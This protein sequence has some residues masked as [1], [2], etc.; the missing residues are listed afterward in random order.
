MLLQFTHRPSPLGAMLLAWDEG[1]Q[2]R[3]LEFVDCEARLMG[4]LRRQYGSYELCSA[5][6]PMAIVDPLD[7]YFAGAIGNLDEITVATGG[8]EFQRQVWAALRTIGPGE[9][10]SY[11][12]LAQ[13]L[14]R[15][16]ASRAVGL[17]NGAN[18]VA[19]VVP[20]HRVI[21]ANGALTGYG[22]GLGRKQW[23]L[24]HERRFAGRG[25]SP[26]Y[27]PGTNRDVRVQ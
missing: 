25:R 12:Q 4:L 21:G 1:R 22:G 11:G 19:I 10:T 17:A 8:T 13:R 9:T 23:L 27:R 14:G 3:A 6:R 24:D 20:C 15:P 7:A 18:P 16:A 2:L 26:Q 5:S